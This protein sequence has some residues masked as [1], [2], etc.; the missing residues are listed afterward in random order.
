MRERYTF[1]IATRDQEGLWKVVVRQ[2]ETFMRSPDD[3]ARAL[4][5]RWIIGNRRHL[6]GGERIIVRHP[7]VDSRRGDQHMKVR[8]RVFKGG[9]DSHAPGPVAIAYLGHNESDY[10]TARPVGPRGG[11]LSRLRLPRQRTGSPTDSVAA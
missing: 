7:H 9:L 5:E 3:I 1:E 4:V 6:T 10:P 8:V 11:L 2:D